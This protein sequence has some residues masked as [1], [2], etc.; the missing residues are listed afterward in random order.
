MDTR[1]R[2]ILLVEDDT[3]LASV[4]RSRLELEGFDVCEANNGEDAL[5]LAVSEH[6]DLILLDVMMPKISGFDVLDILRNTP[7]TTNIRVIMLTALSQPKDKE[8][9]EQLGVDDYLV[10]SQVVIGDVVERVRYHL[11][12][13]K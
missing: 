9:A 13:S 6:P 5:S 3:A 1:K 8:R 11:G 7:E 12:M 4:Y 10:K 2:K